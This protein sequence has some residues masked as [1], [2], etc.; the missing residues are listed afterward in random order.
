MLAVGSFRIEDISADELI[1]NPSVC[2]FFALP[3]GQWFP[4]LCLKNEPF[5]QIN[6]YNELLTNKNNDPAEARLFGS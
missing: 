1:T 6:V 4:P 2:R 5:S 3:G